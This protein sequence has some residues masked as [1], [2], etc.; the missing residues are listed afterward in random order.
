MLSRDELSSPGTSSLGAQT[1]VC[2]LSIP[3]CE[4]E[5]KHFLVK[6]KIK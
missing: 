4:F 5:N 1:N 6:Y 2:A 3:V